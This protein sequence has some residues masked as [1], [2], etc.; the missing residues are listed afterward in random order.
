MYKFA[1]KTYTLLLMKKIALMILALLTTVGTFATNATIE[2]NDNERAF[3]AQNSD[4]AFRL[5]REARNAQSSMLNAQSSMVLS[6]LSITYALGMLNNGAT[7]ETQQQINQVLGSVAGDA[8]ER[9]S[10]I[11]SFCR[12]MLDETG[13][14]DK[15]TKVLI[16]NTVFVNEGQGIRL[17]DAFVEKAVSYYDAEPQ[18]RDFADGLTRDVI[19]QWGSDHTNGMIKEVLSEDDFNKEMASYLLN[20]LY[21]KGTWTNKFKVEDTKKEPFNVSGEVDMMHQNEEFGYKEN[22]LYQAVHLPYGNECFAMTVF[23][24]REGKTIGDLLEKLTANDW[25]KYFE[26]YMVDLALPRFSTDTDQSLKMIMQQLG[27][28]TPFDPKNAEFPYFCNGP[29]FIAMMKQVTK[30]EVNEEGTEA[31]AITT[32]GNAATSIPQMATFHADR[33]F[34]YIISERSTN[35]IFFMGQYTGSTTT[36]IGAPQ[37]ITV[38]KQSA[39]DIYSLTGQRLQAPPTR[40]MYIQGKRIMRR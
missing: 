26:S 39:T 8:S 19:N 25:Y 9:C 10:R 33:P 23:L 4:F 11:N 1:A 21:F 34:F 15:E 24:P 28:P 30:I 20:A 22:D 36:G 16:G 5:F 29:T 37:A 38:Q 18:S 35:T 6:P 2:L 14:L 31:A 40:G 7:G 17:Q 13:T 27:M 3:V 12:K 32:I